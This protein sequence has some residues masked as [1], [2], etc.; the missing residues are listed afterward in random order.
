MIKLESSPVCLGNELHSML[1]RTLLSAMKRFF[2]VDIQYGKA[3]NSLTLNFQ[4]VDSMNF[5]NKNR[6]EIRD[7]PISSYLQYFDCVVGHLLKLFWQFSA[8]IPRARL[9]GTIIS[10]LNDLQN[11]F[12]TT[13]NCDVFK[14]YLQ[15]HKTSKSFLICLLRLFVNLQN[16]VI[17]FCISIYYHY[18]HP[19]SRPSLSTQPTS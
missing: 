12:Q 7:I 16:I 9:L 11:V 1:H 13:K 5:A 4:L 2:C 6:F 17:T 18:F 3:Q 15:S 19:Y 8:F 14:T 10:K